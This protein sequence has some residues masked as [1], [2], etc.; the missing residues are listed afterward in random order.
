MSIGNWMDK[1]VVVHVHNKILLIYKKECIW[2]H[3]TEVDEPG[4]C[5]TELSKSERKRQ[6]LYINAYIWKL[7][8]W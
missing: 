6:I 5:F 2:V 1:E 8:R 4:T 3:S 7:E